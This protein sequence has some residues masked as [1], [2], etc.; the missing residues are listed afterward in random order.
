[1]CWQRFLRCT[2]ISNSVFSPPLGM[3]ADGHATLITRSVGNSQLVVGCWLP[4]LSSQTPRVTK[5]TGCKN[6]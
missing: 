2:V 3:H 1:M 5:M 4:F 6:K